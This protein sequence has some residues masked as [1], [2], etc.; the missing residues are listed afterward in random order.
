MQTRSVFDK[1]FDVWRSPGRF[2]KNPDIIQLPEGR[3]LLVYSDN[4]AHLSQ[5]TQILTILASD[6]NGK[7]WFKLSEVDTADLRRGDERLVTPR[8]SLLKDG[9]VAV[10]VDHDDFGHFHEDQPS[11]NWI[12]WSEDQGKTWSKP[13]VSGIIGFEPDRIMELPD[14]RLAAVTHLMLRR[15]QQFAVILSCSEDGGKTWHRGATIADD[16]F[17]IFCEGALVLLNDGGLACLIRENHGVGY[18]CFVCFS[19]DMGNTWS[20]PQ[21]L[22]FSFHRPYGKQLPDGRVFVTGR[23]TNGG[24]GTY[25]WCGNLREE[26][27]TYSIGGPRLAYQAKLTKEALTITNTP[28]TE[29]RYSLYPIESARSEVVFEA[30]VK[31]E[32]E[33]GETVAFMSVGGLRALKGTAFLEIAPDYIALDG[34]GVDV[35]KAVDM[36]SYR[37]LTISHKNGLLRILVD[38]ETLINQCVFAE[39][40]YNMD[41]YARFLEKWVMFGQLGEKGKSHWKSVRY[42]TKNKNQPDYEWNW[43]ASE[44]RWPD[45][46]QQERFLQLHLN[47]YKQHTSCDQGYSSWLELPDSRIL[48]VDYTNYK[49]PPS[50]SHLYG[51]I[52]DQSEL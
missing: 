5:E 39:E 27:G 47:N 1:V 3:I 25:G 34:K 15:T 23:N 52:L 43:D 2:T 44:L 22:P 19:E 42:R 18:P 37:K 38:G 16:G 24:I 30:E 45:E 12:Y 32:G 11:G 51:V 21:T 26:A 4:D 8:I 31:V 14:G 40:S 49:D 10:L 35:K 7:T 41:F 9:R 17:H 46:Y 48:V 33:A 20:Q 6:D 29:C 36:T 50:K 13:Q 28:D